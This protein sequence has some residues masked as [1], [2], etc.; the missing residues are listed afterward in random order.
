MKASVQKRFYRAE[1]YGK[2]DESN[3][4]FMLDRVKGLIPLLGSLGLGSQGPY[5]IWVIPCE[6]DQSV[7]LIISDF[8]ES[9]HV[10]RGIDLKK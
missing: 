10:R 9:G 3:W 6:I 4:V 2:A 8:N 1:A 5:H 7:R